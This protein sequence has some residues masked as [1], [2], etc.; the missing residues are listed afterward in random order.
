M[1]A[2]SFRTGIK[3]AYD[4]QAQAWSKAEVPNRVGRLQQAKTLSA[5]PMTGDV[6]ETARL[7]SAAVG[8]TPL[9]L[10]GQTAS[11]PYTPVV[12]RSLA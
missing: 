2:R 6:A 8:A 1:E 12:I 10:S 7:Q 11:P 3:A 4:I 5:A 9:G